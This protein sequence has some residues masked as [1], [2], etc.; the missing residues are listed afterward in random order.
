MHKKKLNTLFVLK[1]IILLLF[2]FSNTNSWAKSDKCWI[3]TGPLYRLVAA[4]HLWSRDEWH[5]HRATLLHS[6]LYM[7]VGRS[8]NA[9]CSTSTVDSQF[10]LIK[11][12]LIYFGLIDS[13]YEYLFK[14]GFFF[15]I[16][17]RCVCI[18]SYC[19][20]FLVNCVH[21]Y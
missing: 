11:P 17:S 15:E 14:V 18:C 7:A 2:Y 3:T 9:T 10:T 4:L 21:F 5:N 20:L 16:T 13:I 19:C 8:N 1:I 12:Y 6:L